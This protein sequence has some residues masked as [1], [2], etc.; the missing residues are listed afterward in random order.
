MQDMADDMS[1]VDFDD[2]VANVRSTIR[3][4]RATTAEAVAAGSTNA[5]YRA[6]SSNILTDE[7]ND[8]GGSNPSTIENN[9]YFDGRKVA[10]IL[11][12]YISDRQAWEVRVR[13]N[14]R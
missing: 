2:I 4:N 8:S 14:P 3:V 1:D 7:K 10:R 9:I 12:P 13:L 11:P 6:G 5:I